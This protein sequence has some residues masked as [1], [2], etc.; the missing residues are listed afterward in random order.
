WEFR[1]I[2]L[3]GGGANRDDRISHIVHH[4]GGR[5]DGLIWARPVE[6]IEVNSETSFGAAEVDGAPPDQVGRQDHIFSNLSLHPYR[7][8][9]GIPGA[10]V[11]DKDALTRRPDGLF[12]DVNTAD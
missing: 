5:V 8:M 3:C 11:A 4:S 12:C 10:Q 7:G 2:Q 1:S 9:E 6:Q